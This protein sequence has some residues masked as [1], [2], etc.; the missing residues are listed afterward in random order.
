VEIL[1]ALLYVFGGITWLLLGGDVLVRGALSLSARARISPLVVGVTVVAVGTSAPELVVAVRA[2]V[3]GFPTL[4]L[5]NVVGSNIANVLLVVG[6][7]AIVY[8][9]VCNQPGAAADGKIMFGASVLFFALCTIGGLGRV[10]GVVLLVGAVLFFIHV[11]A[12]SKRE[13]NTEVGSQDIDRI[14]GL[15]R[16]LHVIAGFVLFGAL[17]LPLGA[18][19]LIRGAV[20]MATI[21][22][23][24]N[25]V[26]GLTILA[27]GTSLPELAT[28]VVAALKRESALA[29]GNVIGSNILNLLAI[30][31]VAA[32]VSPV[33][34]EVSTDFIRLHLPVMLMATLLLTLVTSR[35]GTIGRRLG[36]VLVATYVLYTATLF[37]G[38]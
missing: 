31:G 38:R 18:E 17:A 5:G 35:G 32:V 37:V 4:A 22:G 15:P 14:L 16:K 26:V 28:T 20:D 24:P 34:I 33:V 3:L 1:L 10:D 25:S 7:P 23:I 21:L 29:V 6:L 27:V 30:M 8:P 12:V 11:I 2:A 9:M 13:E 36:L 19:L